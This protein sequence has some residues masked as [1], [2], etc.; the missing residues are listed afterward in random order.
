LAL[1]AFWTV[2]L[3]LDLLFAAS[4]ARLC[5]SLSRFSGLC[6]TPIGIDRLPIDDLGL[7]GS[8]GVNEA[9]LAVNISFI[10]HMWK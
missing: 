1:V 4:Q 5:E 6:H 10:N 7:M 8:I 9:E 2:R 3:T